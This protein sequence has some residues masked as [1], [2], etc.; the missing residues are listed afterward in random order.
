MR[1]R[2]HSVLTMGA[3]TLLLLSWRNAALAQATIGASMVTANGG[4]QGVVVQISATTSQDL[5][6]L[7][8]TLTFD[9]SLCGMLENQLIQ[10]AGRTVANPQEGGVGCPSTGRVSVVFFDLSGGAVIPAGDGAVAAW[11]FDVRPDCIRLPVTK[12]HSSCLLA[13]DPTSNH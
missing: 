3:F 1:A 12:M 7:S 8:V 5:T 4:D 10:K 6:L 11:Q 9:S 13:T 2:T